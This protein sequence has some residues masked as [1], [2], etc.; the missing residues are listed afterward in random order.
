MTPFPEVQDLQNT[1]CPASEQLGA[2]IWEPILELIFDD[3]E[4]PWVHIWPDLEFSIETRIR[5]ARPNFDQLLPGDLKE[6]KK[7]TLRAQ[8]KKKN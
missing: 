8:F 5:L 7:F 6:P 1:F 2:H 3:L 4:N